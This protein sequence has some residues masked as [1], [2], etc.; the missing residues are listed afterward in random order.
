MEKRV[1]KRENTAISVGY[2]KN[3][4]NESFHFA[5]SN[6]TFILEFSGL[7]PQPRQDWFAGLF[8]LLTSSR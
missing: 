1:T 5:L 4:K 6:V 7:N 3:Y 2:E 8:A